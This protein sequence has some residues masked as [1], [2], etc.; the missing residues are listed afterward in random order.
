MTYM[1]DVSGLPKLVLMTGQATDIAERS[2]SNDWAGEINSS[3]RALL[4]LIRRSR[5]QFVL[6]TSAAIAAATTIVTVT[7]FAKFGVGPDEVAWRVGFWISIILPMIFGPVLLNTIA[8]LVS[9]LDWVGEELQSQAQRDPLTSLLNRRGLNDALAQAELAPE[10]SVVVIDINRF[11]RVNDEYGHDFGDKTLVY[12]ARWL[13]GAAGRGSLVARLGGDEFIAVTPPGVTF[14]L[15]PTLSIDDV[16]VSIAA[17]AAPLGSDF[18]EALH[19]ADKNLY[20]AKRKSRMD[21][22]A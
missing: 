7:L 10:A 9:L 12:V 1:D 5:A 19:Q 18:G 14:A 20:A 11:K 15:N 22:A 21:D 16:P 13:R 3:E 6:F 4:Q 17:G 8:R 2:R